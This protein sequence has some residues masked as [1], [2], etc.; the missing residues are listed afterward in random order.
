MDLEEK[1]AELERIGADQGRREEA[2]EL[3]YYRTLES[4]HEKWEAREQRALG[5][6]DRLRRDCGGAKGVARVLATPCCL[7]S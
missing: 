6:I 7:R 1:E 4:E 3:Q 2:R 5:E